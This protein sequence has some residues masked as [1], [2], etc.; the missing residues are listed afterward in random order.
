MTQPRPYSKMTSLKSAEGNG[1]KEFVEIEDRIAAAFKAGDAA[2]VGAEYTEDAILMGPGRPALVG[3]QA[4]EAHYQKSFNFVDF[5]LSNHIEE[6]EISG[7]MAYI[8]GVHRTRMTLKKGGVSR[9]STGKYLVVLK[10]Q[11][12]GSWKFFRDAF[13][14]DEKPPIGWR[15][16]LQALLSGFRSKRG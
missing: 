5:E 14:S 12:D 6:A 9:Q 8:R 10:R 15:E 3:R 2:G 16:I 7:E 1:V 11:A 13:N 4:I